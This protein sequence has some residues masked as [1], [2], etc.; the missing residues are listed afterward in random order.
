MNDQTFA[1]SDVYLASSLAAVGHALTGV[2][3]TNPTRCEFI[4]LED[5]ELQESLA[6][7]WRGDLLV[8]AST[9]FTVFRS[10]K[11]RLHAP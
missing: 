8:D 11:W 9:L 3:H 7:F 10:M 4:F 1:T 6:R 5:N 2:D